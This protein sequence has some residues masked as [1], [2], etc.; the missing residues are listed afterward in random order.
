MEKSNSAKS[1]MKDPY[2]LRFSDEKMAKLFDNDIHSVKYVTPD[3]L[4]VRNNLEN[5][6][7][8]VPV[9]VAYMQYQ[10]LKGVYTEDKQI[11]EEIVGWVFKVLRMEK[12]IFPALKANESAYMIYQ[13][14][15]AEL[16]SIYHEEYEQC[17]K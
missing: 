9:Y 1:W 4:A 16:V 11:K 12:E 6:P 10:L 3:Y 8:T 7:E 5:A 14:A 13:A 17:K 2:F 15:T